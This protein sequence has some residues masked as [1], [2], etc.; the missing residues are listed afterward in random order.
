MAW[1]LA[2]RLDSL[3]YRTAALCPPADQGSALRCVKDHTQGALP[4]KTVNC[5]EKTYPHI[6][7][8]RYKSMA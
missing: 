7:L 1:H 5:Y 3:K 2:S 6:E 8:N 4:L